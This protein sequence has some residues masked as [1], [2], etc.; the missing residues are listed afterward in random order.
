MNEVINAILSRRSCKKYKPDMVPD[1]LIDQVIESGLYAAS[2]M[3]W[4]SPIIL[5][6]KDRDTRDLLSGLNAKVM[7]ATEKKQ[8][9]ADRMQQAEE[10]C[11]RKEAEQKK[12]SVQDAINMLTILKAKQEEA[13]ANGE[14]SDID[15]ENEAAKKAI[16]LE[17]QKWEARKKSAEITSNWEKEQQADKEKQAQLQAAAQAR[18]ALLEQYEAAM[19]AK[20]NE[21]ELRKKAGVK[22]SAEEEAQQLYNTALS[23]YIS[24][25][26]KA[27]E[28]GINFSAVQQKATSDIAGFVDTMESELE[29]DLKSHAV[30]FDFIQ[31]MEVPDLLALFCT[32]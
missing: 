25:A 13:R 5:A 19:N 1:Q 28:E 32:M 9:A 23:S 17:I 3:G 7:D 8:Q 16:E 6:V 27:A 31:A 21:I 4:Q 10:T 24:L 12:K 30:S 14:L 20:K 15:K 18:K 26:Q 2:A 11:R 29:A 22:V